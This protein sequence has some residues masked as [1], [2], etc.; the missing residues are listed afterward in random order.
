MYKTVDMQQTSQT[1]L[2]TIGLPCHGRPQGARRALKSLLSQ[3]YENIQILVYENPSDVS[4]VAEAIAEIAGRDPRVTFRRHESNIGALGNFNAL[5]DAAEGDYFM[6]AADDDVWDPDFVGTLLELLL[7]NPDRGSSFGGVRIADSDGQITAILD[8]FSRFDNYDRDERLI[9]F[10]ADPEVLGKAN[11]IYGLHK[12]ESLRKVWD[13]WKR[14]ADNSAWGAD[15]VFVFALLAHHRWIFFDRPLLT[16]YGAKTA[17]RPRWHLFPEDF[18][19]PP[20]EYQQYRDNLANVAPSGEI[21]RLVNRV[22]EMRRR[23]QILVSSW[24]RPVGRIL[25]RILLAGR[26]LKAEV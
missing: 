19:F 4:G 23:R 15:V 6:W 1:P 26:R 21:A 3:S 22:M 10:L 20:K 18:G 9:T 13:N 14:F 12:T 25:S 7:A 16:K 2:V 8:R 17:R 24:R 11:L 5:L